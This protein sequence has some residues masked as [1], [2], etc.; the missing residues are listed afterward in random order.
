MRC[1]RGPSSSPEQVGR[2]QRTDGKVIPKELAKQTQAL[3]QASYPESLQYGDMLATLSVASW[4]ALAWYTWKRLEHAHGDGPPSHLQ[5]LRYLTP[6]PVLGDLFVAPTAL[7]SLEHED[8]ADAG[9]MDNWVFPLLDVL[10]QSCEELAVGSVEG[11]DAL[12]I[13]PVLQL[14][15]E[16]QP[17]W[18]GQSF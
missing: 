3:R 8:D 14:I 10:A 17:G 6:L 9:A 16:L 15:D 2:R 7:H 4:H 1:S 12:C 11:Q 13:R 18:E 5:D